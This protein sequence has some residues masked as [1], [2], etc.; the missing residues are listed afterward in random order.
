SPYGAPGNFM[1]CTVRPGTFFTVT[2]R[3]P[4]RFADPGRICIVVTPPASASVNCGSCGQTESSARTS[5]VFGLVISL[6]S[7]V[8]WMSGDGY[9]PRCEC[10]SMSPG[11][12]HFPVA[13]ITTAS[14]GG[15]PT[16]PTAAT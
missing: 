15:L 9:T 3:P 16:L 1:S 8:D 11:V 7:D 4:N 6:P 2:P 12:T 14:A 10:V 13:S 5:A